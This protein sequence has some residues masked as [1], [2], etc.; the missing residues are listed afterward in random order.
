V[1]VSTRSPRPPGRRRKLGPS[2]GE[3]VERLVALEER[4]T[5]VE[6]GKAPPGDGRSSAK[7]APRTPH[8]CIGC[9]LPL[10]KQ[11]GRCRWC[12]RPL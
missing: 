3:L 9:G 2:V 11:A 4:L 7:P 1:P 12:G 6:E 5:R 8:R 10:R